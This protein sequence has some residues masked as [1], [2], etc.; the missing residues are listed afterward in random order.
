MPY[1]DREVETL[2]CVGSVA[3]I[4][5]AWTNDKRLIYKIV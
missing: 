2:G 5:L 4:E 3:V 1:R